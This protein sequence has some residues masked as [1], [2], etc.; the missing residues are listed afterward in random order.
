MGQP[1]YCSA[2]DAG[3]VGRDAILIA[4]PTKGDS[5]VS[6]CFHGCP[7]FLY[8]HFPPQSPPLHPLDLSLCSQC[9]PHPGI[10]PQSLNSTSCTFP[11][12]CVPVW[13]M[14]GCSKDCLILIPFRLLQISHFTLSLKSFSSDSD[15]CPTVLQFP[16]PPRAGPALLTLLFPP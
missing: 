8:K 16:H 6:P 10:A 4:P 12:T 3:S 14:Y 5:A 15:N 7:A 11:G 9:S 13:G 1:L 2:V